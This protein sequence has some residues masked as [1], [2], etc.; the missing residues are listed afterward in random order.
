VHAARGEYA[1]AEQLAREAIDLSLRSDSPLR[2]GEA[3][4]DL[5]EVFDA[6]ARREEAAAALREALECYERKP[7][8]PLARRTRERLAA[9]QPTQV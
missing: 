6:A 1:E 5:A 3:L 7:V 2:Q 9:L 4:S 8:I